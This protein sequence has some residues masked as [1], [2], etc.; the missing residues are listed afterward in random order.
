[1]WTQGRVGE[2]TNESDTGNFEEAGGVG[3]VSSKSEPQI[4][5]RVSEIRR[6]FTRKRRLWQEDEARTRVGRKGRKVWKVSKHSGKRRK[7]IKQERPVRM[8]GEAHRLSSCL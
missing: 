8:R 5:G 4:H 6:G 2:Q 1:L 7:R 3:R